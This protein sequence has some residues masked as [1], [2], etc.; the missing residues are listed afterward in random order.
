MG[1]YAVYKQITGEI[2]NTGIQC[3]SPGTEKKSQDP[4]KSGIGISII[5][6]TNVGSCPIQFPV[7]PGAS[8]RSGGHHIL[9]TCGKKIACYTRFLLSRNFIVTNQSYNDFVF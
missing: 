7:G 1:R 2:I 8:A 3:I 5:H 4:I 9:F 6:K